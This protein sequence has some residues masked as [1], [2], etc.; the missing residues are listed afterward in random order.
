MDGS[1]DDEAGA[2]DSEAAVDRE[3][4]IPLLRER[5]RVLRRLR[6]VPGEVGDSVA[7][8]RRA[9]K[10]RCL[11][12]AGAGERRADLSFDLGE[13]VASTRSLLV[14]AT[15]PRRRPS[16]SRIAMCSRV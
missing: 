6:E 14:I 13:T 9:G 3:A 2:S 4:E 16:R 10:D 1:G 11:R 8:M 12:E 15:T 7:A 5:W